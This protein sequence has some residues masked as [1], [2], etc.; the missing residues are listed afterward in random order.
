MSFLVDED[1]TY[2]VLVVPLEERISAGWEE[3]WDQ[4]VLQHQHRRGE[5]QDLVQ[6]YIESKYLD[7]SP[8]IPENLIEVV[9]PNICLLRPPNDRQ[10]RQGGGQRRQP[11]KIVV[12]L[13]DMVH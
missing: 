4:V 2:W 3:D 6:K 9:L 11:S 8:N 13:F 7:F 1:D 12:K 5:V 10:P